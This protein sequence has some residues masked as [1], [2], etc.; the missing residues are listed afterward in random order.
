MWMMVAGSPASSFPAKGW[1]WVCGVEFLQE[2]KSEV[3]SPARRPTA[4]VGETPFP[5]FNRTRLPLGLLQ[6]HFGI[7]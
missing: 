4:L 5:L 2:S 6:L 3:Q 1:G 7:C